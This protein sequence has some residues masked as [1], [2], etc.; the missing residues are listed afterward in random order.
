M[1]MVKLKLNDNDELK[2][3]EGKL[4]QRL[5]CRIAED[6]D[7]DDFLIN[8]DLNQNEL[9]YCFNVDECHFEDVYES[10]QDDNG[11]FDDCYLVPVKIILDK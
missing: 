3:A 5:Y 6:I 10:F 11:L 7:S 4:E 9:Y 2:V 1:D 8:E